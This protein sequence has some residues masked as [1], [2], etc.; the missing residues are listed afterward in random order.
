LKKPVLGY[1]DGPVMIDFWA[2]WCGPCKALSPIIDE[3]AEEA[4][5]PCASASSTWTT[6][7]ELAQTFRVMS[8]PYLHLL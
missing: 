7:P 5:P 4:D 1:T 6:T 2:E 8:I 3:I